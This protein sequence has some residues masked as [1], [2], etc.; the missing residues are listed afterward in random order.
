[1][2]YAQPLYRSRAIGGCLTFVAIPLAGRYPLEGLKPK[3]LLK[4]HGIRKD[5]AGVPVNR[6]E[7]RKG[8][9]QYQCLK[10][11]PSGE[12][13]KARSAPSPAKIFMLKKITCKSMEFRMS[14]TSACS[15]SR[16]ITVVRIRRGPNDVVGCLA[17]LKSI[18]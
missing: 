13:L 14:R 15:A 10:P 5:P 12:P 6:L 16:K 9:N 3:G 2:E 7:S 4:A 18:I 11:Y 17:H 1:M 8:G